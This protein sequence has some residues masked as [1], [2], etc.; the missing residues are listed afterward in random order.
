MDIKSEGN[1]KLSKWS[2]IFQFQT[3]IVSKEHVGRMSNAYG[4][5]M[6]NTHENLINTS[7]I[8]KGMKIHLRLPGAGISEGPQGWREPCRAW[9]FSADVPQ[10][11]A[12]DLECH[13]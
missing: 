4:T 3:S 11:G 12:E 5:I 9:S 8:F 10:L 1:V 13:A 6:N 7:T 2:T